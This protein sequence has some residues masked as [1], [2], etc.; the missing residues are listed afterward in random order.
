MIIYFAGS[1]RGGRIDANLYPH[2]IQYISKYGQVLTE[3]IGDLKLTD[4]GEVNLN[5][6]WIYKR[7]IE[8]ICQSDVVIAEVSTPSLGV[9]YEIGKAESMNKKILCLFM[10]QSDKKLSAMIEGNENIKVKSYSTIAEAFNFI[11]DFFNTI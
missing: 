10:N 8:W 5:D 2:L 6:N 9:G 3:H 7:D 11:D 1:I 4:A